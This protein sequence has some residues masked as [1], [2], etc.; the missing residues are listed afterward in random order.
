MWA[1]I[2]F[3]GSAMCE[4]HMM[5]HDLLVWVCENHMMSHDLQQDVT[6]IETWKL[7]LLGLFR[8]FFTPFGALGRQR[9]FSEEKIFYSAKLDMKIQLGAKFQ[10]NTMDSHWEFLERTDART[11]ARTRVNYKVPI[12]LKSGDQK[13]LCTISNPYWYITSCK[14]SRACVVPLHKCTKNV[15][16]K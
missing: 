12:W 8:G 4:N 9:E 16:Y 5:S 1:A 3:G 13:K 7:C 15:M 2:R 6:W 10:K 14:T 11:H